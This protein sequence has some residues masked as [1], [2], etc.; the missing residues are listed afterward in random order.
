MNRIKS[1]LK[2]LLSKDKTTIITIILFLTT[3]LY[4]TAFA[5]F[6]AIYTQP[7]IAPDE[8]YHIKVSEAYSSTLEIPENTEETYKYRDITRIPYLYYWINGRIININ[9]TE[10][11]NLRILRM[12][13]VFYGVLTIVFT[14]LLSKKIIKN[15]YLQLI[16]SFFLSNTL[17]FVFLTGSVNYDNLQN[18]FSI[19][20]IY[21]LIEFLSK[22]TLRKL[23][24]LILLLS[25]GSLTKY[26]FLPLA[27]IIF[28]ITLFN[29]YKD[30]SV[31]FIKNFKP[32]DLALLFFA[33]IIMALNI[34]LYGKNLIKYR[35]IQPSCEQVLT[36]EQCLNN[37][38]YKRNFGLNKKE[39]D[40]LDKYSDLLEEREDPFSYFFDWIYYMAERIFGILGHK[41]Y[42]I[43]PLYLFYYLLYFSIIAVLGIR[44]IFFNN[45]L[46]NSLVAISLFYTLI[47][48]FYENYSFYLENGIIELALQGRYIFP[49]I[50][51][52]YILY[53]HIIESITE[54]YL[55]YLLIIAGLALF[56]L[57]S[58]PV[59]LIQI[60]MDWFRDGIR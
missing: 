31:K 27:A 23:I 37:E 1:I 29:I 46:I 50:S 14:Y 44:K 17:M 13:N 2:N 35:S 48:I 40:T 19:A 5:S 9:E 24:I 22:K 30:R 49:V 8:D 59:D 36:H 26:T 6:F 28:V 15:R 58:I 56:T 53:T 12:V 52:F 43:K 51:A 60:P 3:L 32:I 55:K 18:L 47:L 54:K 34:G 21:F 7:G 33:V 38:I 45:K 42:E 11:T 4:F 20:S 39:F 57:N 10:I 25:L 16:P 41:V